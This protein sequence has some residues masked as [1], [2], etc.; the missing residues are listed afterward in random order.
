MIWQYAMTLDAD[1]M[2]VHKN[3]HFND[4]HFILYVQ[5]YPKFS[6]KVAHRQKQQ[7]NLTNYQWKY[8]VSRKK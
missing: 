3:Q 5:G 6:E 2:L 7:A 8:T 1:N 4:S